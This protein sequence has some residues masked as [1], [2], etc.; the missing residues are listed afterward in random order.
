MYIEVR[1]RCLLSR[2][3]L[4]L[5]LLGSTQIAIAGK[6]SYPEF[7]PVL[8]DEARA[9][10]KKHGM[11]VKFDRSNPWLFVAG[12]PGN[13]TLK[14][15]RADEI[16]RRAVLDIIGLC[17]EAFEKRGRKERFRIVMYRETHEEWRKSLFLGIG[18]L[19]FLEPVIEVAIGRER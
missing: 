10:L 2:F 8:A 11:P 7:L 6:Y 15:H 4:V 12:T 5:G 19:T 3:L 17:M 14:F 1:F 13:Y 16:P 18:I 9:I